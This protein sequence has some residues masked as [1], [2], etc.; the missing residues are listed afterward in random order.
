MQLLL[1]GVPL[2]VLPLEINVM[3]YILVNSTTHP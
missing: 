3:A 2:H 1:T